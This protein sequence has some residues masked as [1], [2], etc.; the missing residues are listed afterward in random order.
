MRRAISARCGVRVGITPPNQS[1]ARRIDSSDASAMLLPATRTASASGF[2]R[3]PLQVA[4][5][6]SAW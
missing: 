2:S 4:Q 5:G 1:S 3:A 6:F